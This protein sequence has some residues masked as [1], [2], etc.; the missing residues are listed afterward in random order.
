[1][2]LTRIL[3][4]LVVVHTNLHR[5]QLFNEKM[6]NLARIRRA[7]SYLG[8]LLNQVPKLQTALLNWVF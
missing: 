1:M 5:R 8:D 4:E 2:L 7:A 6:V 3:K